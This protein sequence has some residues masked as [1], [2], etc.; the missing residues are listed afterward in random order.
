MG[1]QWHPLSQ[2]DL[3]IKELRLLYIMKRKL[4]LCVSISGSVLGLPIYASIREVVWQMLL[5]MK[6]SLQAVQD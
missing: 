5:G 3:Q 2:K 1:M 6:F 4:V